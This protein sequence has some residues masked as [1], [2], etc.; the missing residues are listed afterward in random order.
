MGI[1]PPPSKQ[2]CPH[3]EKEFHAE[4]VG[5]SC[6]WTQS[7]NAITNLI[8]ETPVHFHGASGFPR[9]HLESHSFRHSQSHMLPCKTQPASAPSEA[10]YIGLHAC[11][12][13]YVHMYEEVSV[14]AQRN[15]IWQEM[16]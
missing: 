2:H 5:K 14:Q 3:G 13:L 4:L 1:N 7:L 6:M 10:Y 16:A 9:T 11:V 15:W 8:A 12:C